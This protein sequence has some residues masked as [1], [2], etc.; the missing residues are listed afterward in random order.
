[1]VAHINDQLNQLQATH[2]INLVHTNALRSKQHHCSYSCVS[3][4]NV[5][6][7]SLG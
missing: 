7:V 5:G 6:D 4:D 2:D 1:M 3:Q